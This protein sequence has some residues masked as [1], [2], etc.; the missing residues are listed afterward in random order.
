M[1]AAYI[2][3]ITTAVPPHDVHESFLGFGRLMLANDPRKRSLFDRMAERSGI[4]H[5][6]SFIQ[7][8][9]EMPVL[10]TSGFYRLGDFPDTA[11]RMRLYETHASALA[12]EAVEKLL[13]GED[14]TTITHIVVTSCTG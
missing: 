13:V 14:R 6:W 3:A 1:T 11:A 9:G 10:D 8:G 2:N 5:R 4:A 12:V 7:P